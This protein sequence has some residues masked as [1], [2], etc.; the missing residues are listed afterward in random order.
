VGEKLED[1]R[2]FIALIKKNKMMKEGKNTFRRKIMNYPKR[3]GGN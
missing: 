1:E 2:T 3:K